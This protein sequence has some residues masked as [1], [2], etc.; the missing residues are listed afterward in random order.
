MTDQETGLSCDTKILTEIERQF[1]HANNTK[2]KIFFMRYDIRFPEGFNHADNGVFREFQSKFMKNLSRKGL[3]PQYVAVREQSK[4]KHQHYHVALLLD[5]QKTQSIHN[6]IATA[7][8]LWDSTLG[9]P[10]RENGY[11]LIDDCT[12]SR[13]GEKQVNG[14]MLR[15]DDPEME[16][17][18][19][20][21]FKRA[22]YLAKTSTKGYAPKG[23]REL[24]SSRIP[25][26]L[27]VPDI[28]ANP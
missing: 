23:Q 7:E 9:L 5:G 22:S 2:S 15:P 11:G 18:R 21:C 28:P 25:Q 20:E 6:H 1:E 13:E 3:K 17:K 27:T 24:F 8:R 4:E 12:T 16:A 14:V 26:G 19:D 10:E